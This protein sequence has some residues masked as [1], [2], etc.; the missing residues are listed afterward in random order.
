[1]LADEPN[2]VDYLTLIAALIAAI[3]P[4]VK[5]WEIW[6]SDNERF[7]LH[8]EWI[9]FGPNHEI[10]EA[11][12]LFVL[13]KSANPIFITAIRFRTGLFWRKKHAYTAMQY[14]DPT[15][16][17]FPYLVDPGKKHQFILQDYAAEKHYEQIGWK[18]GLSKVFRR[19][20]LWLEIE[21]AAKSSRIIGA[22]RVMSW[23]SRP[24]W[25]T[26]KKD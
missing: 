7:D 23:K 26:A 20:W 5:I 17:N 22:E 10:G 11:P 13:N 3:G 21:T 18:S 9:D 8:I 1:M 2:W 4:L 12:F 14:D 6:R 19:S 16:I 15:D 24:A 25:T